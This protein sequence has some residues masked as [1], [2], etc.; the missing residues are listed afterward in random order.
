MSD[1]ASF[2]RESYP[3]DSVR[4]REVYLHA[5][6]LTASEDPCKV[7]TVLGSCVSVCLF[8]PRRRAGGA[9]HYLLPHPVGDTGNSARFGSVSTLRLIDAMLAFGCRK[10]DLQAKVFGGASLLGAVRMSSMDLGGRNASLAVSMLTAAGIPIVAED[11]G[12][13]RGR[14]LIFHTDD[15]S[16]WVRSL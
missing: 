7:T 1:S 16:A 6:Q 4:R 11:V 9:N 14:R 10:E 3:D 5:G 13:E 8:D 12:G 15:G 2:R